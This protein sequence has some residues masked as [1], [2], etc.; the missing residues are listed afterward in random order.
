VYVSFS[1]YMYLSPP[2]KRVTPP[3]LPPILQH[4]GRPECVDILVGV[5]GTN[6]YSTGMTHTYFY[7]ACCRPESAGVVTS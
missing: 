6:C 3:P 4:T 1:H 5:G 7:S 2:S